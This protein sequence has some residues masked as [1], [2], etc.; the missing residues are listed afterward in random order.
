MRRWWPDKERRRHPKESEGEADERREKIGGILG[1]GVP[2]RG[3]GVSRVDLGA[4]RGL[5]R[6]PV[7]PDFFASTYPDLGALLD[8]F[9][10]LSPDIISLV[11]EQFHFIWWS[12]LQTT[13]I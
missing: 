9:L 6:G 7:G 3:N 13:L 5:F 1:I 11:K 10:I 4:S 8:M 2:I 12:Q